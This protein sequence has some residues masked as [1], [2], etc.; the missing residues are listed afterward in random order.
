M[1]KTLV[2]LAMVAMFGLA[3]SP[4]SADVLFTIQEGSVPGTTPNL[5]SADLINGSY[6]EQLTIF[7]NLTFS[8][9]AVADFGQYLLNA[10]PQISY[11][12]NNPSLTSY[13]LYGLFN[14]TGTVNPGAQSFTGST[15]SVQLYVD[16]NS[17]TTKTLVNGSTPVMLGGGTT[18]DYLVASSSNFESGFGIFSG[19]T[20]AF[21]LF[22]RNLVL[23]SGDNNG[24]GG[25]NTAFAGLQ[26][27]DLFFTSPRPFNLRANLDGDFNQPS[28]AP[29]EQTLRGDLSIVFLAVPEPEGLA[30]MGIAL[31]GLGFSQRRRKLAK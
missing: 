21:D 31:A 14:A 6:R 22:F 18:D 27:G 15:G 30:L 23:T 10:V 16:P 20:G 13:R 26:N 19:T 5:V 2:S 17:D 8:T 24:I 11:L 12:G 28:F 3:A 1:K 29:G 25:A 4:A 9:F 7:N